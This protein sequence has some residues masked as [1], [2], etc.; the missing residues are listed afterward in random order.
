MD[1]WKTRLRQAREAKGWNKTKFAREVG[2]SNPTVTDWE[3]ATGDGGIKEI[4]GTNLTKV[5]AV[6][7]IDPNWL[8]HGDSGGAPSKGGVGQSTP[9]ASESATPPQGRAAEALGL[10]AET[11][12][13]LRLL[14]VY[15]LAGEDGRAAIDIVV[16]KIRRRLQ[17]S[18][19][20]GLH[21]R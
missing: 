3:K 17:D 18:D 10:K 20:A 2:V 4:A 1:D 7:D 6:L 19:F 12:A 13:E 8:L 21:Q 5:C 11:A 14:S 9:P 16:E 15:R